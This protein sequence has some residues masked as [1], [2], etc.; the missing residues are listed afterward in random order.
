MKLTCFHKVWLIV[1]AAVM[2]FGIVFGAGFVLGLLRILFIVPRFG[3]RIAE[4][5]EAPVMLLVI[6]FAAKW[7]VHKFKLA[8]SVVPVGVFWSL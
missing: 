5:L 8:K 3:A 2:Y 1:K 6:V 7:V 4:L